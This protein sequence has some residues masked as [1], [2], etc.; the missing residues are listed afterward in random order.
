MRTKVFILIPFS[1]LQAYC[2]NT[3][4]RATVFDEDI[5][6][7]TKLTMKYIF[8][9]NRIFAHAISPGLCG[10]VDLAFSKPLFSVLGIFVN[11]VNLYLL[12]S[13]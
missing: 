7:F 11:T 3:G 10:G 6:G 9:S 13:L 5:K 4:I 12:F 2:I 1:R 8:P